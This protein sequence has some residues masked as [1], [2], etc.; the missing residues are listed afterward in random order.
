MKTDKEIIKY[1]LDFLQDNL[2][3]YDVINIMNKGEEYEGD[4]YEEEFLKD[5]KTLYTKLTLLSK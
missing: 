3:E 2:D 4:D 1:A 5:R